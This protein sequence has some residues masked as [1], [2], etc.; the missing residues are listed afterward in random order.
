MCIRDRTRRFPCITIHL[1]AGAPL[2]EGYVLPEERFL[3]ILLLGHADYDEVNRTVYIRRGHSSLLIAGGETPLARMHDLSWGI[4]LPPPV[5]EEPVYEKVSVLPACVRRSVTGTLSRLIARQDMCGGLVGEFRPEAS[6][7][8]QLPENAM[9]AVALEM[10]GFHDRAAAAL[11]FLQRSWA[12]NRI[13]A[14]TMGLGQCCY[15]DQ[16]LPEGGLPAFA[17]LAAE[18]VSREDASL[19]RILAPMVE[20][21]MR[22]MTDSLRGN[23]LGWN[24]REACFND[25][26]VL[27]PVSGQGSALN[28][29]LYLAAAKAAQNW[30][31]PPLSTAVRQHAEAVRRTFASHFIPGG[32]W[33]MVSP[34]RRDGGTARIRYGICGRCL[35][36]GRWPLQPCWLE[37]APDG[38]Y[39]CFSCRC[40]P[41][42][43]LI[44]DP[45][46]RHPCS[47]LALIA[48]SL[49]LSF[50]SIPMIPNLSSEDL[51]MGGYD[52]SFW[53]GLRL[54]C[55]LTRT[56]AGRRCRILPMR[57][58]ADISGLRIPA[59][60]FRAVFAA[61]W[62]IMRLH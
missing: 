13:F 61:V 3:R 62:W 25:R 44:Y 34:T 31:R 56:S 36:E 43:K 33:S 24:G 8:A 4:T 17:V 52:R 42:P 10:A 58:D 20:C 51:F 11:H 45:A 16:Q 29:L 57:L 28:T 12:K 48:C 6:F 19:R 49:G 18:L 22:H 38:L 55:A 14:R 23:M 60:A 7:F 35:L 54:L 59:G 47:G 39:V 5:W 53:L 50:D 37:R 9:A 21:A 32:V 27:A 2:D 41:G 1:A 40:L 46:E 26:M 30:L 15:P